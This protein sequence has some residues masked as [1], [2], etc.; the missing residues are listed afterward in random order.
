MNDKIFALTTLAICIGLL[1]AGM[2]ANAGQLE[3]NTTLSI[4][5][6]I[7][8][9]STS[10]SP[11]PPLPTTSLPL[12]RPLQLPPST[13]T[14]PYSNS[15][16]KS[17]PYTFSFTNPKSNSHTNPNSI[18]HPLQQHATTI[19]PFGLEKLMIQ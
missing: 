7:Q 8:Q 11:T 3:K 2:P 19:M 14:P 1:L 4:N 18:S 6:I 15:N 9:T 17:N 5:G 10:P 16:T 13:P 12:Q